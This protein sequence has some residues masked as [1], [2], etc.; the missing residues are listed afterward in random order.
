MSE[1]AQGPEPT[2]KPFWRTGT[3]RKRPIAI[4]AW[5]VPAIEPGDP[6]FHTPPPQWIMDA[7]ADGRMV[8]EAQHESDWLHFRIRTLEGEML[9]EPDGWIIKGV[10]GEL[11]PCRPDIFEATYEPV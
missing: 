10:K 9:A 8:P 11:Y 3:Y 1:V 7:L 5:R 4:E 2:A 6:S